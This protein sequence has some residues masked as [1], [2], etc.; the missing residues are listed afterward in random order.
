[1]RARL[2]Q[3]TAAVTACLDDYDPYGATLAI[4]PLLDD[5]TNWYVRR[6]R[7]RFWKSEHDADKEAAYTTLYDVL[8]ALAQLLAPMVPFVTEAM[9]QNLVGS[10]SRVA[11]SGVDSDAC[12][13]VHHCDWP[14]ADPEA[15]DEDL[16]DRMALAMQIAA[17][18]RS[19][20]ST[21]GVKLRQPLAG[22]KVYVGARTPD[23]GGLAELVV[24]ELNVKALEFVDTEADLVEYE[25]GLLPNVLGPKH[26][27]RYPL[28]RKAVAAASAAELAR[29]FQAGLS[30]AV[31]MEDGGPAVV[32]LPEEV[33]IRTH[34][35]EGYAVAE[36]K[37][38]VVAIDVTVTPELAREGMGRDLVRRIQTLRKEADFQ[39]D[40]R[41]VT[42]YEG[43]DE[44]VAVVAEQG[45]YIRAET[46]SVDLVA[47][48]MPDDVARHDAFLLDG[49]QVVLGVRKTR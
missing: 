7:R 18:G 26:G 16:L 17:L 13:S 42:F 24:D 39:L 34:G 14:A 29:R 4:E 47:G 11:V 21:S 3:V 1:M 36:E 40:D 37:G 25:I 33:E 30:A 9:Y 32:L 43:D 45:A 19:A 49:H 15:V 46:L 5:L 20:R 38:I 8:V 28:L 35:R 10:Q 27:R 2:N 6:S 23:L 12:E 44:V 31:E 41:I 48:P 22:A